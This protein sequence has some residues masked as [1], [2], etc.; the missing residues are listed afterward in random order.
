LRL[1]SG[2]EKTS[3]R[4][5]HDLTFTMPKSKSKR[6]RYQP[7]PK[8]N[9]PPSPRWVPVVFFTMLGLGFVAIL[10][11]YALPGVILFFDNDWFLWGG[12]GLMAAAFVVATRWR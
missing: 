12:L 11:R 5:G 2:P 10:A 1:A 4:A 7:P 6:R 3:A 8:P 9:P